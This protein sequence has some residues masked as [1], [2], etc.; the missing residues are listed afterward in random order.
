VHRKPAADAYAERSSLT[1]EEV[2]RPLAA[3]G[4]GVKVADLLP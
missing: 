3:P 4:A 1:A 2:I